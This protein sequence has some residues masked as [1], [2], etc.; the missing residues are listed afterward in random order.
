LNWLKHTSNEEG[1]SIGCDDKVNIL[2]LAGILRN[3][4]I[5]QT[6][7]LPIKETEKNNMHGWLPS[8]SDPPNNVQHFPSFPPPQSFF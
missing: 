3:T 5:M 6:W 2:L 8:P 1:E 7:L 4:G